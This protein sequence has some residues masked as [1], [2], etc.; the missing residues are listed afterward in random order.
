MTLINFINEFPDKEGYK[1]K[2]KEYR[3]H[4]DVCLNGS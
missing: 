3:D 2:F 1:L 4:I